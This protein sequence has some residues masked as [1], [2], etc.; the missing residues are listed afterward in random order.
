MKFLK[1]GNK[2]PYLGIFRSYFQKIIAIFE[3]NPF[4]FILLQSFRQK[5][6]SWN[7]ASKIPYLGVLG[8]S[9][10]QVLSYLKSGLSNLSYWKFGAKIKIVKCQTKNVWF[11]YFWFRIL[12]INCY[13][14]IN[15]LKFLKQE[16]LISFSEF[17]YGVRFFWRFG[18]GSIL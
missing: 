18:F 1:F 5:L 6:K 3:I 8:S 12:K 9:F 11:G 4:K 16:F 10:E 14:C 7:L 17:C 13:I 15:I 2:M